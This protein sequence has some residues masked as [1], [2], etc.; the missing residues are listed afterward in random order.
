[1]I[2]LSTVSWDYTR[3]ALAQMGAKILVPERRLPGLPQRWHCPHLSIA[4][5]GRSQ[6]DLARRTA[7][8][9]KAPVGCREPCAVRSTEMKASN[10]RGSIWVLLLAATA[11][12]A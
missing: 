10:W 11:E 3:T 5:V 2:H 8:R 12:P 1:M 6:S 7:R 9:Y 4:Q